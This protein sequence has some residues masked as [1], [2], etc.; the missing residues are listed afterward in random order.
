[1]RFV[2][3]WVHVYTAGLR[4]SVRGERREEI[5]ADL[6]EQAMEATLTG[7]TSGL[8][9][10]VLMRWAL[11]TPDDLVWRVAQLG[12]R[13]DSGAKET[14]MVQS[15]TSRTMAYGVGGLALVLL[16]AVL[17]FTVANQFR[18]GWTVSSIEYQ[19]LGYAWLPDTFWVLIVTWPL[20]F[21]LILGGFGVM[22]RSPSL[23]AFLVVVGSAAF[24]LV[25]FWLIIPLIA[26]IALSV[27]AVR[28]ARRLDKQR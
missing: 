3:G 20:A 2:R 8:G 9:T 4:P 18:R 10:H 17:T 7:R 22:R 24:A 6:W 19:S 11:G 23:G 16:A 28:R 21:G 1:M 13:N 27:Y 25:L 14:A 26:A 15:S 5:E 12:K